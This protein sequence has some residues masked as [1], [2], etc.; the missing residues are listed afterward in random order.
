ML[1]STLTSVEESD[2]EISSSDEASI[3]Y[4]G[5]LT[6]LSDTQL[7]KYRGQNGEIILSEYQCQLM[8]GLPRCPRVRTL[9]DAIT[10]YLV[11]RPSCWECDIFTNN[12]YYDFEDCWS[13]Y[14]WRGRYW[15]HNSVTEE[16]FYTDASKEWKAYCYQHSV[17]WLNGRRWFWG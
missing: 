17:W 4:C 3:T 10:M 16:W 2:S 13:K 12:Y 15:M 9:L 8:R 6:L 1:Q 11:K 5:V 7:R 14:Q